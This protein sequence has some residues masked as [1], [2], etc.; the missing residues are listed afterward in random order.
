MVQIVRDP[1][2]ILIAV[3]LPVLLLFL[4]GYGVNLDTARIRVGLAVEDDGAAARSLALSYA[5]SRWFQVVRTDGIVAL[6]QDLTAGDIRAIIVIPPGFSRGAAAGNV[7][8]V[9][10]LTDGSGPNTAAFAAAHAQGV[11]QAW[12][13]Q[14]RAAPEPRITVEP[15][16]W[17][18]PELKSRD[19]L[20]PGSI[21]LVMAMIGSLLTALV[22]A[23]E[24]ERGTVEAIFATPVTMT[25]FLASKL[26]PYFLLGLVSMSLCTVLAVGVFGVPFRGS[27]LAL[28]AMTACFLAPSLG[29]GLFISSATRS[30]FVASQIAL[31]TAFL[32]SMLLSGFLFEISSMPTPIRW[33]TLLI[34][35]R[36]F[37]PCL[38]TVFLAGDLWS[39]FLPNM[40]ALLGFGLV[41]FALAF[42]VTR[43][44]LD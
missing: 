40:A 10:I 7:R 39:V 4:F 20:V 14:G 25:E 11:L 5:Q 17:F 33:L 15:R 12:G 3:V 35:A 2:T 41:F 23:R 18:N 24:W 43:R 26:G 31:L 36:Y 21:A 30:Q 28:A 16:V 1:A 6:R 38:T 27:V 9:E 8:P 37:I 22:V 29:L 19:F 32:P 13:R 44:S 42:R 34:P